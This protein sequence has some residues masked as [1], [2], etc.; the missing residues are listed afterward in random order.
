MANEAAQEAVDVVCPGCGGSSVRTVQ[1]ACAE[2]RADEKDDWRSGGEPER[3]SLPDRL[4]A[5]PG[6]TDAFDSFLHF[7][8]GTVIAGL[9]VGL[10]YTGTRQDNPLYTVGGVLWAVILFAVTIVVIRG[11]ARERDVVNVGEPR[12]ERMR[13]AAYHCSACDSV[14]C[15]DGSEWQGTLTPEQFKKLMWTT[16]GYADRLAPDDKAR[17]ATVPAE[18]LPRTGGQHR[19]A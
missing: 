7:V 8:E 10:A 13:R 2:E 14:W 6:S 3:G 9:G 5:S 1:Q 15:P 16:A 12:A 19:Y 4:A 18:A 17:E 11:E